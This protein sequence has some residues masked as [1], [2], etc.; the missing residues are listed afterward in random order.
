[1]KKFFKLSFLKVTVFIGCFLFSFLTGNSQTTY[2]LTTAGQGSA[3]TPGNWNTGGVNGGGTA[4]TVFSNS[5]DIF[6]ISSG[7]AASFL[8]NGTNI[9]FAGT[10]QVD[11]SI[12]IGTGTNNSS[13]TVGVNGTILLNSSATQITFGTSGGSGNNT[14][15][16]GTSGTLKTANTAGI[17]GMSCSIV[18]NGVRTSATLP[19]SANYEFNGTANQGTLGLPSGITGIVTINN[20]GNTVTLSATLSIASGGSLIINTGSILNPGAFTTTTINGGATLTV[21]GTLDFTNAAGLI[22]SGTSGTSTLAMG[23]TGTIKTVDDNGIG[24]VALASFT[25]QVG[26]AWDMTSISTNGTVEYY[27]NATSGQTITDRDYNNLTITGSTQTK[28]WTIT[29]TRSVNGNL[30]I[31]ASAPLTLSGSQ[32]INLKG[33]WS[34][35]GTFTAGTGTIEFNGTAAQTIGGSNATT[36]NNITINN[37][38][39]VT[40]NQPVSLNGIMTFT[41]GKVTSSS[42]NSLTFNAGSSASGA[43]DA[44]FVSGPVTKTGASAFT[45]PVGNTTGNNPNRY[46]PISIGATGSTN[47]FVAQYFRT[48]PIVAVGGSRDAGIYGISV[49]EYWSLVQSSGTNTADVTID[50]NQYSPCNGNA[51]ITTTLGLILAW[52]DPVQTKWENSQGTAINYTN[53]GDYSSGTLERTSVTFSASPAVNYFTFGNVDENGSPLPVKLGPVT[54]FEKNNGVQINWTA[55]FEENL[56]KYVVE[57]S[58]DGSIFMP[59]GEVNANNITS[60]SK[61]GFFDAKPLAGVSFYRL[62]NLDI[63]GKSG[64]SNIVRVNLGKTG[65]DLR[66]YPNPTTNGTISYQSTDMPKGN[67]S[68]RIFNGAGQ[69]VYNQ[70]VAHQGGAI[71]QTIQL[72]NSLLAGL[73]NLR[74]ESETTIIGT[75]T[76][77]VQ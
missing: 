64:L 74:M 9:I 71:S 6:I 19:T 56:D 31:N 28:T 8:V 37:S 54:A 68:I 47:T 20:S 43:S 10:L 51:Y 70:R 63:D 72:P 77:L 5:S 21:N 27:R 14:F 52:F 36:F 23:S 35:S 33:N 67:Y 11:G 18:L 61:Y 38:N 44:S 13:V 40:L 59:I 75:K 29:A 46:H 4:A 45:F 60:E 30:T 17:L 39:G 65:A 2:Y 34:N 26:G 12:V 32:T 22:R 15:V 73:Y 1:M 76:F 42:A 25:T 41:N 50:W 66:L 24:P 58:A 69:Q 55:Y 7:I 16:L 62:R 3:A 48:N 57:R 53:S 49:C